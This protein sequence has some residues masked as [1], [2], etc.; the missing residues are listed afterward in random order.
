MLTHT[1]L[2]IRSAH[3]KEAGGEELD[4]KEGDFA[5]GAVGCAV[6][7]HIS[8]GRVTQAELQMHLS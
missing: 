5:G 8:T 3:S 4:R 1:E 2:F 7:S 6:A